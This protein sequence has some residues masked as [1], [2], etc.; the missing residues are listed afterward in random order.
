MNNTVNEKSFLFV[1]GC[2]RSGTTALWQ[3]LMGSNDIFLGVE[4]F[5]GTMARRNPETLQPALFSK[6]RFFT[7]QEGDT[8]YNDLASFHVFEPYYSTAEAD[9]DAASLIG[10]KIPKLYVDFENFGIRFT[11]AKVI[12]IIRNIFD[13]CLSYQRRKENPA[14]GWQLGYKDAVQDW[15][16]SI[17]NYLKY[18]GKEFS[19]L[20]V[21]YENL[22]AVNDPTV[23]QR[24]VNQIADF[25]AITDR[26]NLLLAYESMLA[27]AQGLENHRLGD[28]LDSDAK[29]YVLL[30]ADID[31]Y[32]QLLAG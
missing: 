8:H 3:T 4:R 7:M 23:S 32:R 17:R 20:V 10:D 5:G 25:T 13:V 26:Q 19:G 2:P 28:K 24:V 31:G 1:C 14:D 6:E 21:Q 30:E 16:L 29:R 9:Y 15:N 11:D 18:A 22:F 27:D 12:F